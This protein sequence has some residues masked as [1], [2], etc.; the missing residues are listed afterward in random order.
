MLPGK[1]LILG[2][3]PGDAVSMPNVSAFDHQLMLLLDGSLTIKEITEQ[4]NANNIICEESDVLQAL[5][6]F[7]EQLLREDALR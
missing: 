1:H 2:G 7:D 4:L 3:V 5:H 6:V